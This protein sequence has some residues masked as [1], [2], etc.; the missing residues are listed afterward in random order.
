MKTPAL[1][2][3]LSVFV[4]LCALAAAPPC[5]DDANGRATV[6]YCG[7]LEQVEI[8]TDRFFATRHDSSNVPVR[9][10]KRQTVS[11]LSTEAATYSANTGLQTHLEGYL[12]GKPRSDATWRGITPRL[13]LELDPSVDIRVFRRAAGATLAIRPDYAPRSLVLFYPDIASAF[14]ALDTVRSAPGVLRAEPLMAV[15]RA[16]KFIPNDRLF[17]FSS[18]PAGDYA[19]RV[20][21]WENV[22]TWQAPPDATSKAYQWNLRN[23]GENLPSPLLMEPNVGDLIVPGNFCDIRAD[24]A[25]DRTHPIN[26][27]PIRGNNIQ[28]LIVDDGVDISHP[29][30]TGGTTAGAISPVPSHHANYV[31]PGWDPINPNNPTPSP[32]FIAFDTHGTACAGIV[33]ARANNAQRDIS[34]IAPACTLMGIRLL[35]GFPTPLENA[36]SLAWGSTQQDTNQDGV[37]DTND[38]RQGNLL[39]DVCSNSWGP[40]AQTADDLYPLHPLE[41]QAFEYA[42]RPGNNR[43][44]FVFAAGNEGDGRFNTNYSETTNRPETMAIGCVSDIGR[45]IAYSN[46]GAG[47]LCVAP[48]SGDELPPLMKWTSAPPGWP[49]GKPIRK[50]PPIEP[51][52]IPP[53]FRSARRPTQGIVTLSTQGRI[54]RNFNG[55]SSTAPQVAGIV[56]LMLQAN[57]QLGWRDVQEILMRSCRMVNDVR[58]DINDQPFPTQWRMAPM[59]KPF[60]HSFGAGLVDADKAVRIASK[61]KNLPTQTKIKMTG[62]AGRLIPDNNRT[63]VSM[64]VPGP[65]IGMRVEHVVTRVK[66]YHGRRGDTGIRIFSPPNRA[67]IFGGQSDLFLPHRED[68]N[69]SV[70]NTEPAFDTATDWQFMSRR[71]W[72]YRAAGGSP[73][74]IVQVWDDTNAGT[75]LNPTVA[76]PVYVPVA[77]PTDPTKQKVAALEVTYY[78]CFGETSLNDPPN[79]PVQNVNVGQG[80]TV[81]TRNIR[82]TGSVS[83][84]P[85]TAYEFFI[86]ENIVP[87]QP[88]LPT[89]GLTQFMIARVRSAANPAVTM[90]ITLDRATGTYTFTPTNLGTFIFPVMVEND[91]GY[92]TPREIRI[93]VRQATPTFEQ[94]R[95]LNFTAAE[96][97]N[98]AISGPNA[99]PD[100]DGLQNYL[101]YA[102]GTQPEVAEDPLLPAVEVSATEIS[103]TYSQNLASTEAILLPQISENLASWENVTGDTPGIIVEQVSLVD[104]IRTYRIRIPLTDA[105]RYFRLFATKA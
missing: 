61:W 70:E 104:S 91:L 103:Y 9:L 44:M 1:V 72:G 53:D 86:A 49:S 56:A 27:L 99:D 83:L 32:S 94:W 28:V 48:S 92:S 25:W 50:N 73:Q 60:Q 12:A 47:L 81:E 93:V 38:P 89:T 51:W 8:S 102:M 15:K 41:T 80:T 39:A 85:I 36:N 68:F 26:N 78:G 17:S 24:L 75:N 6:R 96:L 54:D 87:L 97:A 10:G 18:A 88:T 67:D 16:S 2:T 13:Y 64:F 40:S 3:C 33:G 79:L 22:R 62:P 77:N 71:H 105:R 100:L 45:R 82:A 74:W 23:T 46:P 14:Q 19:P 7:R 57:S 65:A 95:A 21:I 90:D 42:N 101:E 58:K 29:D 5:L 37:I 43:T 30:W 34:G 55:T 69:A 76:D 31:D 4:P 66:W 84:F 63:G 11:Q 98:P 20:K 52:D 59:G 35:G